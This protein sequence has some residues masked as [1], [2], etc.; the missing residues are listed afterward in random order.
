MR[1]FIIPIPPAEATKI[2]LDGDLYRHLITVLRLKPGCLVNLATAA[3][4]SFTGEILTAGG[5]SVTLA[6]CPH[7]PPSSRSPLRIVL[8]QGMPK[9]D[10]LELIIQK[11]TE[12]G[13]TRIVPFPA[14][15]SITRIP[16][17][18]MPERLTRWQRIAA[19]AARQSGAAIPEIIPAASLASALTSCDTT[20][21]LLP[22]EDEKSSHLQQIMATSPA[23]SSVALLIGPEGGFPLA[24][25][26]LAKS[27][28]FQTVCLGP[29]I[30][31]TETAGFTLMAILQHV[32]GDI[33]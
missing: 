13:V 32:W 25:V 5:G 11:A 20:Q 22:W 16:D 14:E 26:T 10:K 6:I 24:E 2:T 21:R 28:G 33:S 30:L 18:R 17:Q 4:D 27:F 1:R 23:P 3:G 15:R 9:S 19:E 8:Y 12:L 7:A 29:R 31:R